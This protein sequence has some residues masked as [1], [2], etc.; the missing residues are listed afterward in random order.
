M[1]NTEMQDQLGRRI[2]S[3]LTLATD[4]LPHEVA[5]RLRAA[6]AQAVAKRQ[7]VSIQQ[8]AGSLSRSGGEAS[9]GAD[10]EG[11][12]AWWRRIASVLPLL[13]L[14]AGLFTINVVQNE[15]RASELA[16]V[17]SALLT[18]ALPPAAYADPGFLQFLK[19]GR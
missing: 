9:L 8:V 12:S 4:E 19:S 2:A 15:R 1:T 5:E 14:V 3:R 17:D 11:G 18:D 7:R 10:D 16:E 6:R 13:A